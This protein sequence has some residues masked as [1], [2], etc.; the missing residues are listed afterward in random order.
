M[1][2]YVALLRGINVGPKKRIRMDDLRALIE[3]L[4]YSDVKTYVNSGNVVFSADGPQDNLALA[5]GIEGALAAHHELDVPVVVRSGD[6][7]VRI[8]A[9]NPFPEHAAHHKTLHVSFL[10]EE[11]AA[12]LVDSLARVERGE[13]DYRVLGKDVYLHYPNGMTGAVFMVNGLDKALKV[14]STS[15]NWRTVVTLAKMTVE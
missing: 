6:E 9:N 1:S 8:V 4:G 2:R 15:R 13:D 3:G 10:S 11:P 14:T 12:D 5:N 7:L